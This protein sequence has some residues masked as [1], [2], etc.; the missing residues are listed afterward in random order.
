MADD[1]QNPGQQKRVPLGEP[2]DLS[3]EDL[4]RLS[5]VTDADIEDLKQAVAENLGK[6]RTKK[7]TAKIS[8]RSRDKNAG[9]HKT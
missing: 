3:D 6:Q 7:K 4:D 8:K 5:T 9:V 2:L 1:T